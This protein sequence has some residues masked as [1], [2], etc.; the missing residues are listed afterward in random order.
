MDEFMNNYLQDE[1]SQKHYL[2]SSLDEYLVDGDFKQ[3][4]KCLERVI[5]ARDSVNN[6]AKKAKI[7]RKNLYN[8]FNGESKPQLETIVKILHELGFKLK[9][10]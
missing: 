9:V 6:F 5:K 3:F 8:I 2:S 4:F 1:E 7:N 10:A